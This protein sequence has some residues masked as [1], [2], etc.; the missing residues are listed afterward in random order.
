MKMILLGNCRD[1]ARH[2]VEI[3]SWARNPLAE[4]TPF[5]QYSWAIPPEI[6]G[7]YSPISNFKSI[8]N[9]KSKKTNDFKQLTYVVQILTGQ[10]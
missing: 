1:S 9:K 6:S 5:F 7:E 2:S 10:Q 8:S 4:R 3:G